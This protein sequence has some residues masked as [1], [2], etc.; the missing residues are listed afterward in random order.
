[1][2]ERELGRYNKLE[3]KGGRVIEKESK[4]ERERERAMGLERDKE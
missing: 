4:R 3:I 2:R 1:M